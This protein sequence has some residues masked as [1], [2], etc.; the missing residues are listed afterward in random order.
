MK[1]VFEKSV[2]IS[3]TKVLNV[4]K[5]DLFLEYQKNI[6]CII[7]RLINSDKRLIRMKILASPAY[8]DPAKYL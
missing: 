7:P 1:H 8:L 3:P 5:H 4:I 2:K 6:V